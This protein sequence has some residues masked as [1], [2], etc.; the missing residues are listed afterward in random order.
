[1]QQWDKACRPRACYQDGAWRVPSGFPVRRC[2]DD[3]GRGR[4]RNRA[5]GLAGPI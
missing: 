3:A 5:A 1:V 4:E 2:V